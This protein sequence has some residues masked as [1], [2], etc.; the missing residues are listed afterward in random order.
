MMDLPL[1]DDDAEYNA[2]LGQL[3]HE[4]LTLRSWVNSPLPGVRRKRL[5]RIPAHSADQPERVTT[6]VNYAP[7]S[8]FSPHTHPLGEEFLVLEGIFSDE[9]G[10]YPAGYYVRNPPGSEHQPFSHSGCTI[11]VKLAQFDPADSEF[12]RIDSHQA[13]WQG[14]VGGVQE[15][16]LHEFGMEQVFMLRMPAGSVWQHA[17]PAGAELYVLQ[18]CVVVASLQ[19]Q[20]NQWL[21]LPEGDHAQVCMQAL[22]NSV[23]WLKLGHLLSGRQNES[24][25]T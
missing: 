16:G 6:L 13:V 14:P 5:D 8:Y 25:A 1:S 20:A 19:L 22:Q 18:G 15:L 21:R 17:M 2:D 23:V 7:G 9:Y 10:D 4:D 12:K 11:L 24:A 3:A